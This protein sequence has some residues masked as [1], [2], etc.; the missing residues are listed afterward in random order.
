MFVDQCI[1]SYATVPAPIVLD[2]DHYGETGPGSKTSSTQT[3]RR[4]TWRYVGNL[5]AA[6]RLTGKQCRRVLSDAGNGS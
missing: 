5:E 2:M 1:A 4:P 6:A 3:G